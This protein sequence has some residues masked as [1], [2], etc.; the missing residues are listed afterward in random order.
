MGLRFVCPLQL[1]RSGRFGLVQGL[2]FAHQ[3]DVESMHLSN[4]FRGLLLYSPWEVSPRRG[5]TLGVVMLII[6][7]WFAPSWVS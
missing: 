2:S 1:L 4:D 7:Y 6:T 3:F 5:P